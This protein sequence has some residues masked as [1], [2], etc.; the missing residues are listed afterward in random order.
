MKMEGK[1]EDG[2]TVRRLRNS[3][4]M[5]GQCEDGRTV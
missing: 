2:G 5:E 4:K 1:C 3:G